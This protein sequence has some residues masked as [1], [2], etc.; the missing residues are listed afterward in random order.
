MILWFIPF[1][2]SVS[3]Y[4]SFKSDESKQ[5]LGAIIQPN[6]DPY[7][8]KFETS[9]Q[10]LARTWSKMLKSKLNDNNLDF[11][12]DSL[13]AVPDVIVF[14]ETFLHEGMMESR[15]S[16]FK[17]L[18]EFD[19]LLALYPKTSLIVG[20][21]T[22]EILNSKTKTSRNISGSKKRYYDIY[23][24]AFVMTNKRPVDFYHKSKLVV[25]VEYMPFGSFI[26]DYFGLS[27]GEIIPPST[28]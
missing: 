5:K 28:W 3:I 14:P 1:F 17:S 19:S 23:N 16:N 18:H 10:H 6:L 15:A 20:A 27:M 8:E 25:G 21:M 26:R 4:L 9:D 2:L 22:Y 13:E 11:K 24:S 12:P 7:T